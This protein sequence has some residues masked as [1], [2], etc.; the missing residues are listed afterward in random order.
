MSSTEAMAAQLKA[1]FGDRL[2]MVAQFGA[3]SNTCAIVDSLTMADLERCAALGTEWKGA[4]LESP[5]LLT[6][7]EL[8]RAVDAFP[9]ELNEILAT[10]RVLHGDD[11]FAG[12]SVAAADVRRACEVQ[13][14]GHVVHLR[15]GF[16]ESA[17]SAKAVAQLV[18]A[19]VVRFRSL[20]ASIARLDGSTTNELVARLGLGNFEKGF[21]DS[22]QA[23]ERLV[24]FVDRWS[25]K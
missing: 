20:L 12:L 18:S 13:A 2:R 10:R 17:G 7:D 8:A 5:L 22:L 1:I 23:A 16:I 9:L 3:D 15:E 25:G 21:Q 11:M 14:R 24:D 6:R 4:R 19:S